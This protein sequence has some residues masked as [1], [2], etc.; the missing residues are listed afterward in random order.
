M[1]FSSRS[2]A[3]RFIVANVICYDH[4]KKAIEKRGEFPGYVRSLQILEMEIKEAQEFLRRG[5]E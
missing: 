4:F 5:R 2:D 1:Y 3:K